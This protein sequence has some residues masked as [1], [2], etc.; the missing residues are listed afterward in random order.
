MKEKEVESQKR[1][2]ECDKKEGNN[3]SNNKKPVWAGESE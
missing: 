1:V 3:T 2:I